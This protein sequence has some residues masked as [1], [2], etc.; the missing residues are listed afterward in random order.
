MKDWI[1]MMIKLLSSDPTPPQ[2]IV[3]VERG[4]D[5]LFFIPHKGIYI[6]P[7][8]VVLLLQKGGKDK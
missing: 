3:K 2:S 6:I 7:S 1:V 8:R 4:K 5:F